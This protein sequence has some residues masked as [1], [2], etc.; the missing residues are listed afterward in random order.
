MEPKRFVALTVGAVVAVVVW[1]WLLAKSFALVDSSSSFGV[2]IGFALLAAL[3]GVAAWAAT[4]GGRW[5]W[6]RAQVK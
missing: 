4:V 1:F 3:G 5:V 6:Q 2:L